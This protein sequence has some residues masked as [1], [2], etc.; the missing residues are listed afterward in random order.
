VSTLRIA[1]RGDWRHAPENSLEAMLAALRVPACDGLEFDVRAAGDG[2]PVL[3]HDR[4][5]ARVQ[6]HRAAVGELTAPQLA[7]HGIPT[8]AEVLAAVPGDV[9]LDVELKDDPG[10]A[11]LDVLA[12][13]RGE[14]LR[15][16]VV[17][18]FEAR[19][20]ERAREARPAWP[21]WLN[22]ERLDRATIRRAVELGCRA[23]SAE[24]HAVDARSIAEARAAG[25][26]IAAWTARDVATFDRLASLGVIAVCV[27][28]AAL[29]G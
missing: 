8:L 16:A 4:T 25:L 15:N 14:E 26:K 21:R 7:T 6:G 1:H 11:A 29:D 20:L 18:S 12:A 24:L 19:T 10:P 13:A 9:F 23:V 17:S 28:A 22:S 2:T 27:E 5:L 3:L